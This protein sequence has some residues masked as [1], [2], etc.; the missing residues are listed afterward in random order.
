M[1]RLHYDLLIKFKFF[2]IFTKKLKINELYIT[3]KQQ[4]L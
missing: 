1:L 2:S 3:S 4:K